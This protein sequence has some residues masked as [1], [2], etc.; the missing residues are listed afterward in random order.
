[1]TDEREEA[2]EDMR[3]GSLD[4]LLGKV[5]FMSSTEMDI[6][7]LE[8][9]NLMLIGASWIAARILKSDSPEDIRGTMD[10]LAAAIKKH[11]EVSKIIKD[12]DNGPEGDAEN[13]AHLAGLLLLLKLLK[14]P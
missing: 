8:A 11:A 14:K 10:E 5:G 12:I 6:D 13:R 1:M 2:L 4:D 7:P 9:I 3:G